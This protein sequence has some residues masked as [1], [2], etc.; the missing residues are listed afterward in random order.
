MGTTA[1]TDLAEQLVDAING[2]YGSH[3][4]ERAAHAKGTLLAGSFTATPEAA[5]LSRAAHL[6]GD[7]FR[8]TV[9]FSNGSG[10]PEVPDSQIDGRGMAVKFYLPDGSTTDLIGLTLPCF[11]VR[12]PEDFLAF[13]QARAPDPQTGEPDAARVGEFFAAHPE[14]QPAIQAFLGLR[15]AASYAQLTY[16]SI[17]AYRLL[18][19]DDSTRFA[20]YRLDP[21]AGQAELSADD[22]A[23]RGP[24]YLQ[25]ELLERLSSGPIGFDVT[26]QLAADGDPTDDPTA[27]WP[28]DRPTVVAGRI[29]LTGPET[30]REQGDDVLVFDPT[31]VTDGIE[32]SADPILHARSG[33]Y[34]V[35]VAR[36]TAAN[37]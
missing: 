4:G 26:L 18:A 33:A 16:N 22:V 12:T 1:D 13:Q 19:A 28:V 37:E 21:D 7:P 30:E 8:V 6:Q 23:D 5:A 11:F 14:A 35:S 2:V 15:P 25:Q 27:A 10:D 34:R 17:H 20:R 29:E 9:R 3:P 32:C 36:R 31:R 24:D